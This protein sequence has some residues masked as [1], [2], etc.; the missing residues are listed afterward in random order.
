M[1]LETFNYT[2]KE[3]WSIKAFPNMDSEQTLVL[4]F[5]APE[6]IDNPAPLKELAQHYPKSKIIGCS[7]AGEILGPNIMDN[8]MAVAVAQFEKTTIQIK[9]V[10]V[11][12]AEDSF[13]AGKEIA[14]QLNNNELRSILVLSS[15]LLINGS[16]IVNGLNSIE[17][18]NVIITGGLAGDGAH[19]KNP[20]VIFNGEIYTGDH[21]VAV[22]LCGK[23]LQIGF[24]SRGGWDIFGPERFITRSKNNILYELDGQPALALYKDYLG[25]RANELPSVGLLFP[26]AIRKDE[27]DKRQLIRTFQAVDEKEQSLTFVGDMP[28]GYR[29]QLMHANFNRLIASAGEAG[30]DA[31]NKMQI[32][33]TGPTLAVAISCIGRRLLLGERTEEETEAILSTLPP[34]T[35]QLGFYSYGELCPH[36]AGTCDFHNQTMTI[37]TFHEN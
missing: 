32:A 35:K 26:L 24:A 28:T 27:S 36:N 25:D 3:G 6:I 14:N 15:G 31:S 34:G 2:M 7:S 1:K 4:I 13:P 29:A 23:S 16:E 37:T 8:S 18:E 30:I 12:K 5:A 17:K 20:W 33:N 19:F 11:N 10:T 9:K 22:G 21:I